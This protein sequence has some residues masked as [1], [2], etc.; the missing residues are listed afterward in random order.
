M[1]KRLFIIL[2][3]LAV[4]LAAPLPAPDAGSAYTGAGGQASGGNVNKVSK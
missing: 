3:F 2:P 1:F 4:I